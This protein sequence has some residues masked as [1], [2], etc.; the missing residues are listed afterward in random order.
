MGY[1]NMVTLNLARYVGGVNVT[2]AHRGDK[3]QMDAPEITYVSN[4]DHQRVLDFMTDV[5]A[6]DDQMFPDASKYP[7][8]LQSG[9]C[10]I[11]PSSSCYGVGMADV[12]RIISI[13]RENALDAVVSSNVLGT[14]IR[15][16]QANAH[17][18]ADD[19]LARVHSAVWRNP[20][21]VNNYNIQ[22]SYTRTRESMGKSQ[23]D[24]RV[25]SVALAAYV[26]SVAIAESLIDK[27]DAPSAKAHFK[28][29]SEP[30]PEKSS[31]G[32]D[33]GGLMGL[34]G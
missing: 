20:L 25:A 10:N 33:F 12:D 28:K 18:T 27:V 5:I 32:M 23:S 13:V 16:G 19:L 24:E 6:G 7:L 26:R 31:G 34:F 14:L 17:I 21:N 4:K 11:G 8:F 9:Q 3:G 22:L 15:Q 29:V 1:L 2:Y 30:E